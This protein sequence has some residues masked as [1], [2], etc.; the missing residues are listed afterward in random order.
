MLPTDTKPLLAPEE[1]W[2]RPPG[3]LTEASPPEAVQE[4]KK[5][6]VTGVRRRPGNP[7]DEGT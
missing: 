7:R 1:P 5:V 4:K 2:N 6:E 3:T